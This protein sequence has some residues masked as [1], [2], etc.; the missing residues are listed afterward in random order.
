[1]LTTQEMQKREKIKKYNWLQRGP[2]A[3]YYYNNDDRL[4]AEMQNDDV[5][6]PSALN[7][8]ADVRPVEVK[9]APEPAP[10]IAFC[11]PGWNHVDNAVLMP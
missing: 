6:L 7:G 2:V 1:M 10:G 8:P 9:P 11:R 5:Y 3:E 4:I